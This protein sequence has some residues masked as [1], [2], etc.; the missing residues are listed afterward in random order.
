LNGVV[1]GTKLFQ[2]RSKS[3]RAEEKKNIIELQ[4]TS[5]VNK[6]D[7][8]ES[9]DV[10]LLDLLKN[11]VSNGIRDISSGRTLIKKGT[12]LTSKRL[13]SYNLVQLLVTSRLYHLGCQHKSGLRG[14][15][16]AADKNFGIKCQANMA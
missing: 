1:I 16:L 7:L 3:A 9:R 13:N 2:K 4:K 12:K 8:K 14:S 5:A 11:E 10:K 6:K 15:V